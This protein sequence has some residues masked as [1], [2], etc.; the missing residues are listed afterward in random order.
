MANA[1]TMELEVGAG[2]VVVIDA[3]FEMGALKGDARMTRLDGAKARENVG[4]T[5]LILW[6]VAPA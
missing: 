3:M 2:E 6:E 5:K 1:G 4:A